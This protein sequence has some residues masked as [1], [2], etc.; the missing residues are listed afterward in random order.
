MLCSSTHLPQPEGFGK[1]MIFKGLLRKRETAGQRLYGAIVAAGRHPLLYAEWQVPDTLDGRFDM[2]TL[3]LFLV[4]DR[5]KGG[6]D[7]FR[8][9]L[10]DTFF[11]DMDR[12]LR[13]MGVGD[14]SVGKKV[15]KMAESFYG[16]VAAYDKAITSGGHD[17]HDALARNIFPDGAT[18]SCVAKLSGHVL[19]MRESLASQAEGD[20]AAGSVSFPEPRP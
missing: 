8:Q 7:A 15:R 11:D 4:L 3:H 20:L 16:R 1:H 14:V 6:H 10:V 19:A 5:L 17:L 13:E 9:Q 2:I 18:A 12:S